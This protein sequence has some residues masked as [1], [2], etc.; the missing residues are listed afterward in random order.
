MTDKPFDQVRDK[1]HTIIECIHQGHDTTR[2]IREQTIFSNRDVNYSFD[3]LEDLGLIE[4]EAPDCR[5]T[6]V[7]DGQKRNFKAPR[8]AEL[9]RSGKEYLSRIEDGQNLYRDLSHEEL[10]TRVR[11]LE[12]ELEAVQ[13]QME[14][15]RQQVLEKL[16]D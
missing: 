6:E 10:V 1:D 2:T 16:D 3:K 5:V 11:G 14:V 15:F 8:Q 9:T 7:V 12:D 4:T 13:D